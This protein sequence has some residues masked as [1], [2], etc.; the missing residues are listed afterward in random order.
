MNIHAMKTFIIEP[1]LSESMV[2]VWD[3]KVISQC[4]KMIST[5]TC[6][7]EGATDLLHDAMLIEPR[8]PAKRYAR[9]LKLQPGEIRQR[10]LKV[11]A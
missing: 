8:L 6:T 5:T 1:H 7:R 10:R 3:F 9:P 2:N 4:G 11:G